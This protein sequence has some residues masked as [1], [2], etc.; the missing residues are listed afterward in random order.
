M[1]MKYRLTF[2]AVGACMA[3]L[4]L[5]FLLGTQAT[6]HHNLAADA[7]VITPTLE[8]TIVP[9]PVFSATMSIIP[10]QIQL[11]VGES[12]VVT[13]TIAVSQG[14]SF[15]IYELS[16]QQSSPNGGA[17]TYVSPSTPTVGPPVSN[18]F[19]YTLTAVTTGTVTL[20]GQAYGERYCGDYWAWTYVNG[21]SP[22]IQIGD[23]PH[24]VYMPVVNKE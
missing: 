17:F 24:Q 16:L 13:V 19:T 22:F 3:F 4:W 15:P 2:I 21:V 18:P 12:V 6:T 8:P 20:N 10:N 11:A 1:L 7:L 23:W 5:T 14:C 9:T